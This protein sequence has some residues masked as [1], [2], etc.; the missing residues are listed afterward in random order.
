MRSLAVAVFA[1][2]VLAADMARACEEDRLIQCTSATYCA[3]E[4]AADGEWV[5]YRALVGPDRIP[6]VP[7]NNEL[8]LIFVE[9]DGTFGNQ[10]V[11]SMGS[12]GDCFWTFEK[13]YVS[14]NPRK[15]LSWK[16]L[17]EP[18]HAQ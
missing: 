8:V 2:A 6:R 3:H 13:S 11:Y 10:R 15:I 5:R 12:F 14:D 4:S 16:R 1:L 7:D 18:Q 17:D 9:V